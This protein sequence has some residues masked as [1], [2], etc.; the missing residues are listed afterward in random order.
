M[1][2]VR[3]S[4]SVCSSERHEP[5]EY[6]PKAFGKSGDDRM[7]ELEELSLAD[8]RQAIYGVAVA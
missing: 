3:M 6:D 1:R 7:L 4:C 2:L 5:P 8:R